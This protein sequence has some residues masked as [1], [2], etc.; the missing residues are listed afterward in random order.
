LRYFCPISSVFLNQKK[1]S[2][3]EFFVVDCHC[4]VLKH[5]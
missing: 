2:I 3:C 4:K 1:G 5:L